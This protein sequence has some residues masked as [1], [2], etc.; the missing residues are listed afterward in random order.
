MTDELKQKA[1]QLYL[2]NQGNYDE[3][4]SDYGE[5]SEIQRRDRLAYQDELSGQMALQLVEVDKKINVLIDALSNTVVPKLASN[6]ALMIPNLMQP[7]DSEAFNASVN[8]LKNI[9]DL[10]EMGGLGYVAGKWAFAKEPLLNAQGQ[11]VLDKYGQPVMVIPDFNL[12]LTEFR[13]LLNLINTVGRQPNF[14]GPY[15]GRSSNWSYSATKQAGYIKSKY[16]DYYVR[17]N[18]K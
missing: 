9:A 15:I 17:K 13:S 10:L 4:R 8:D 2:L 14:Y 3:L 11:P 5:L 6:L 18:L 12:A 7:V 1:N 16:G